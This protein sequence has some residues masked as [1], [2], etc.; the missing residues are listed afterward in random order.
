[1]GL[2]QKEK[3]IKRFGSFV[4]QVVL[5]SAVFGIFLFALYWVMV[6]QSNKN[7]VKEQTKRTGDMVFAMF[8]TAMQNGWGREQIDVMTGR[9]NASEKELQVKLYRGPIVD[10]LYGKRENQP[11]GVMVDED[12]MELLENGNIRYHYAVKFDQA[13][14]QCHTN[15]S[16]GE[17]AGTLELTFPIGEFWVSSTYVLKIIAAIFFVTLVSITLVLYF[18]LKRQFINPLDSLVLQIDSIMSERDLRKELTIN[19]SIGELDHLKNVFNKI[20]SQLADSFEAIQTTAEV[21]PLTGAYNRVRLNKLLMEMEHSPMNGSIVL[22]DLDKF[23]PIND[24]YGH[25]A[26]DEALK[27]FVSVL[28]QNL[29]GRDCLFRLGGDEFMVIFPSTLLGDARS[30]AEEIRSEVE[31]TPLSVPGGVVN[32]EC[33]LGA[34][35][36]DNIS[37]EFAT[38]FR[39]ADQEMYADKKRRYP[40][41]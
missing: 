41:V 13:C 26:G 37:L 9:I 28:R 19:T 2:F 21:D 38:A 11:A 16:V 36:V 31:R 25:D 1:M 15:A 29:K 14:L 12:T 4:K 5:F 39:T 23:K 8:Y 3:S 24:T 40:D 10:A 6:S 17:T 32:I 30:L 35:Y 20:R 18:M 34:A 7:P 22:F 27:R 33:S